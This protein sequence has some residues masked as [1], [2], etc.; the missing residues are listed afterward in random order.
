MQTYTHP[1]ADEIEALLRAARRARSEAFASFFARIWAR[2]TGHG[3]VSPAGAK[4]A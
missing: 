2:L 4:F 1:S 3:H